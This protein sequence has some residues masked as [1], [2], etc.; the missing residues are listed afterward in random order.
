MLVLARGSSDPPACA[1]LATQVRSMQRVA[2]TRLSVQR[3]GEMDSNAVGGI[4]K[5]GASVPKLLHKSAQSMWN[6][7]LMKRFRGE[8]GGNS[9]GVHKWVRECSGEGSE[10][11][12]HEGSEEG[13]E[14]ALHQNP[15]NPSLHN[16]S[17]PLLKNPSKPLSQPFQNPFQTSSYTLLQNTHLKHL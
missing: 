4:N 9:K 17:N 8:V 1:P 10:G 5:P 7:K 12:S 11:D 3:H 16:R 2:S 6:C 14:V 13:P 15:C